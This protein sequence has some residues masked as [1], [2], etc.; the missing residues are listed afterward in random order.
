MTI[1][2]TVKQLA[3]KID[4]TLLKADAQEADFE[5]LCQEARSYGFKMV[6]INSYPVALCKK[7]LDG[8]LVHVGAAIGFPLGQTTIQTK[9]FETKEAIKNGADEIDYVINLSKL[10]DGDDKYIEEEMQTIVDICKKEDVLSKVILETCYLTDDEKKKV[11]EIAKEVQPDFVKTTT[12]FGSAGA[13]ADVKL[14]KEVVGDK[15]KVKAAGGI[16]DLKTAKDMLEAGA[17][18][19]GMSSSVKVIEEYRAEQS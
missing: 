4:H 17:D 2:L 10:K 14:M 3:N 18:R 16:R 11:C 5:K 8:S 13:T 7:L 12:G 1:N 15:V 19:L 6:A 9:A